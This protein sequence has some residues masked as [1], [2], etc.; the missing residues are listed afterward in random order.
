MKQLFLYALFL[1]TALSVNAS[2]DSKAHELFVQY[3]TM[4]EAGAEQGTVSLQTWKIIKPLLLEEQDF[5]FSVCTIF[6]KVEGRPVVQSAEVMI[7]PAN[8]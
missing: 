3:Q 4:R 7:N 5:K 8:E 6:Y 1:C 2:N